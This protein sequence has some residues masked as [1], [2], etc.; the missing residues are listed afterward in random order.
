MSN[1]VTIGS[2]LLDAVTIV[3]ALGEHDKTTIPFNL[4]PPCSGKMKGKTLQLM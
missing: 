2:G 3:T 4:K 1:D